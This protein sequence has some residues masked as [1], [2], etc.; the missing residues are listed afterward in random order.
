[1][2]QIQVRR[3]TAA[4]WVAANPILAQ[5]ELGYEIDD[6]GI[7]VGDGSTAWNTLGYFPI[8]ISAVGGD[9]TTALGVGSINVGHA[10]D[11]TITRVS[12]GVIAVEGNAVP[13]ANNSLE[14]FT[15]S[16]SNSIGVG[17]VELGH[18]TDT[19]LSRSAAGVLAVEGV[20]VDTVSAANTLTNKRITPRIGTTASSATPSIDC[21]LYDQ[22]NIT[23]LAAAITS[24]TV[25]GTPTD[26]QKLLVRIKDNGTA[27]AIAWGSSFLAS[28][29]AALPTTTVISKT[30]LVGFIY[31][32]VAAKWVC[33]AADAT[34]Y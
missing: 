1:M 32:S 23:A 10:S 25:T 22:Y 26:G 3:G 24:V 19:T 20:V 34:G 33:V 27:R 5:G 15:A 30:H 28:G 29:S 2:T 8:N 11:T 31:D 14:V 16:T 9:T 7:K 17:T 13:T 4:A 18:A 6:H 12:S 21:G